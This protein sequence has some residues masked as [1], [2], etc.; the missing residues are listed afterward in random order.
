MN[1]DNFRR[2]LREYSHRPL[3]MARTHGRLRY[4]LGDSSQRNSLSTLLRDF[5]SSEYDLEIDDLVSQTRSSAQG[6]G[7]T[8]VPSVQS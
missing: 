5:M 2:H 1:N 6:L 7:G 3:G 4:L 8:E